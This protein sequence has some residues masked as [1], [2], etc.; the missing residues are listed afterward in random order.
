MGR[1]ISADNYP[2]TGQG[3]TG[4][5]MF[6]YCGNNPVDRCDSQGTLWEIVIAGVIASVVS[7]VSNAISTAI[8]GGSVEECVVAGLI[9][10]GSAAVGFGVAIATGFSPAGNLA[11]RAVAS[12]ICDLG[13]TYYL[14]GKITANDLLATAVD[15]TLD[16]GFS[17]YIY[18]YT[19]PINDFVKQ[20]FVNSMYDG[21]FDVF[22]V[23]AQKFDENARNAATQATHS[24]GGSTVREGGIRR[25]HVMVAM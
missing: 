6:A 3:L 1:F 18:S 9:G 20:T 16:V 10:A 5:N 15:V 11:A 19:D 8:N 23:Y 14:N 25:S 17:H 12:T 24:S 21:G 7:G 13:T 22:E 4:N 2:S